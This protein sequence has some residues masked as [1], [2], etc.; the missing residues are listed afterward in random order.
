MEHG[1]DKDSKF[2]INALVPSNFEKLFKVETQ[3]RN[4]NR[5]DIIIDALNLYFAKFDHMK[6]VDELTQK[7]IEDD[8]SI[9]VPK[10]LYTKLL[11]LKEKD[12]ELEIKKNK[13]QTV[14]LNI[15]D[16]EKISYIKISLNDKKSLFKVLI[17]N[18]QS[19]EKQ[20]IQ[21]IEMNQKIKKLEENFSKLLK[22]DEEN[23]T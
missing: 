23:K 12:L 3:K 8:T 1:K 20:R 14:L 11:G 5:T 19:N 9:M 21:I 7:I 13:L 22:P 6:F 10:Q 18:H 16:D 17:E 2:Q 4:C 15:S